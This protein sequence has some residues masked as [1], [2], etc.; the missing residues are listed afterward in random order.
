[1]GTLQ[2]EGGAELMNIQVSRTGGDAVA[3]RVQST[4]TTDDLRDTVANALNIG[5]FGF[6]LLCEDFT[7]LGSGILSELGLQDGAVLTVVL[8]SARDYSKM[9]I[10]EKV[11][12]TG[13][14]PNGIAIDDK[15]NLY[16]SHFWGELKAYNA[17]F[18]LVCQEK[19]DGAP[20]QMTIAPSGELVVASG[21]GL[22]VLDAVCLRQL[23]FLDGIP[24][25]G[26]AVVG[27]LVYVT[28]PSTNKL[29]VHQ[30]IDGKHV[31][32]CEPGLS[33]PQALCAIEDRLLAVAD[34][35]NNRVALL[36]IQTLKVK[37][38][39]P[40]QLDVDNAEEARKSKLK[41]PNDVIVDS[42]CNLLVMDTGN[43]RIAVFNEDGKLLTS[44]LEGFFRDHG[45][46]YSYLFYNPVTG[47][48]VVSNNDEHCIT[49]FSPIFS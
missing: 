23:R 46:T 17:E 43:E 21:S 14:Y 13:K 10:P 37:S 27:D 38:Q 11:L 8:E 2:D 20:R 24:S 25:A 7:P 41:N 19:I 5:P 49:V 3:V 44:A 28:D 35:G 33:R 45:N 12:K 9:T 40:S 4:S 16:V 22:H 34:R 48:I 29:H 36:D 15:G 6:R 1:M 32:T 42:A 47:A 31:S 18:E 39:L 26:V 30:F